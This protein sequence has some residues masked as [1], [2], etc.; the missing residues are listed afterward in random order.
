[1]DE[2]C[3]MDVRVYG[4]PSMLLSN[5]LQGAVAVVI[6]ALRMTT[7]AAFAVRNG[8]AGILAV[9]EVED[10]RQE[11][12]RH[13]AL[14]GG[15]RGAMRIEG[16][17][18]ANSPLEYTHDAVAGR[19]IVVT[20]TNGTRAIAAC[21]DAERVL[22][23]AFVN[24]K[25]VAHACMGAERLALVCAGTNGRFSLEDALA[26][27]AI[28]ARLRERGAH[29]RLC[30]MAL[31]CERMYIAARG[32]LHAALS[33]TAHYGRLVSLS[34]A[35]DLHECLMEDTIDAVPERGTDGFFA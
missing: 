6:D 1:M 17:D 8:C 32:D 31:A 9:S 29:M 24:A 11:A 30:D 2:S 13:G 12:A 10:A 22:L 33:D 35:R 25:A 20:T 26:A 28:V 3:V 34:L 27:G 16:F 4:V 15:E 14:L 18:F 21:G 19:R 5:D 7:V 23:G